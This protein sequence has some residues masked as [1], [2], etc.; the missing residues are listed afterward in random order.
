M[1]ASKNTTVNCE[2]RELKLRTRA[3]SP[4]WWSLTGQGVPSS[5][6]LLWGW[7]SLAGYHSGSPACHGPLA[8]LWGCAGKVFNHVSEQS[9]YLCAHKTQAAE[10][11]LPLPPKALCKP[12]S[13]TKRGKPNQ[14]ICAKPSTVTAPLPVQQ[15]SELEPFCA[16]VQPQALSA[17]IN[18]SQMPA[19]TEQYPKMTVYSTKS[20]GAT[21]ALDLPR[22]LDLPKP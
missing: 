4:P 13:W 22:P 5:E 12:S 16:L 2:L 7:Q 19:T 1:D 14:L 8:H 15:T 17:E 9:V 20:L 18:L 10:R 11:S 21:D 6:T 3:Q